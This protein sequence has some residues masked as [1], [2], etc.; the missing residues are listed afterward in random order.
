MDC[1]GWKIITSQIVCSADSANRL[2]PCRALYLDYFIG[3]SVGT[4]E[5]YTV[6][7][8]AFQQHRAVLELVTFVGD[9]KNLRGSLPSGASRSSACTSPGRFLSPDIHG[10]SSLRI[11]AL[12]RHSCVTRDKTVLKLQICR[13]SGR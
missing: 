8:R 1:V 6:G 3:K 10:E 11:M 2:I 5:V 13:M 12:A 9:W 4:T 7:T